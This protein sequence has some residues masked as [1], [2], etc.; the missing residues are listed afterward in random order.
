MIKLPTKSTVYKNIERDS[1]SRGSIV[2]IVDH[3]IQNVSI[4]ENNPNAHRSNHYHHKDFHF[5]YIIEGE[6]DYFFKSINSEKISYLK[7]EKGDT[8]FTPAKEI[9]SCFFQIPTTLVVSSGFPRDQKTYEEDTVR[10]DFI[11]QKNIINMLKKYG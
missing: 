4:I 11:N 5:M 6:I 2:S 8:I 7:L 1:D 9:H 10:V 3:S